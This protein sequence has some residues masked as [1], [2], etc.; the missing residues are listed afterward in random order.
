MGVADVTDPTPEERAEMNVG[1]IA[2]RVRW[3]PAGVKVVDKPQEFVAAEI[4]AAVAAERKRTLFLY[5]YVRERLETT[6]MLHELTL[7]FGDA[8]PDCNC[9]EAACPHERQFPPSESEIIYVVDA[10]IRARGEDA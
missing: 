10:A 2:S 8:P 6:D 1:G 7:L 4:R 9:R 5:R 3:T